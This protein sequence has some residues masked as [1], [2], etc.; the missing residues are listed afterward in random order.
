MDSSLPGSSVHGTFQAR[1]LESVVLSFSR[2]SSWSRN[3]TG[4]SCIAGRFLS[5]APPEKSTCLRA[6]CFRLILYI[7]CPTSGIT[8][9]SK[10]PCFLSLGS[11]EVKCANCTCYCWI[12]FDFRLSQMIE[13]EQICVE[14][15]IYTL[16]FLK[17]SGN[18]II[19]F[20]HSLQSIVGNSTS[21]F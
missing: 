20:C 18:I 12:V 4:V 8:S 13:G 1:I 7:Y 11:V 6:W 3:Q 19:L 17:Y 15:C 16:E 5:S 9:I 2:R 21:H 14:I 10:E